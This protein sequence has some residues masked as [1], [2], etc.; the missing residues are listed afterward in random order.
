MS[1]SGTPRQTPA[2]AAARRFETW[3]R[4]RS[5][6]ATENRA[7][8]ETTSKKVPERSQRVASARKSAAAPEGE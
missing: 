2:A 6:E 4:P 3:N 5:G 8:A 7:P 1:Y